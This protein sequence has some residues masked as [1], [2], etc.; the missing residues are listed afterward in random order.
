[1]YLL[2]FCVQKLKSLSHA[3]FMCGH[4]VAGEGERGGGVEFSFGFGELKTPQ[5]IIWFKYSFLLPW[6]VAGVWVSLYY[7]F[8]MSFLV[9]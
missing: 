7:A 1:M 6:G 3:G 9:L 2:S 4:G 5:V 8:L